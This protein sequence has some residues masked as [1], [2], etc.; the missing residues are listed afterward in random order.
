M[1]NIYLVYEIAMSEHA[2]R[3]AQL[4]RRWVAGGVRIERPSLL[5][6]V[7]ITLRNRL[8]SIKHPSRGVPLIAGGA[9]AK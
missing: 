1:L 9:P 2:E 3:N 7:V 8:Y 6:R 4:S 5:S